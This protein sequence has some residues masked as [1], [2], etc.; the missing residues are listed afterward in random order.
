MVMAFAG[1]LLLEKEV[2]PYKYA[3]DGDYGGGETAYIDKAPWSID[4]GVGECCLKQYKLVADED[5]S[6]ASYRLIKW[7]DLRG[8]PVLKTDDRTI[9]ISRRKVVFKWYSAVPEIQRYLE[10]LS[11]QDTVRVLARDS[12]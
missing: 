6:D 10:S 8:Q 5:M 3:L 7:I 4:C 2:L 11:L 12:V 1:A 9:K